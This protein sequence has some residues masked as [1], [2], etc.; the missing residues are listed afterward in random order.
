MT[1]A[2]F[3][4]TQTWLPYRKIRYSTGISSK[5][6]INGLPYQIPENGRASGVMLFF[7]FLKN[8]IV[9]FKSSEVALLLLKS[10]E[11]SAGCSK[12]IDWPEYLFQPMKTLK[13][14]RSICLCACARSIFV[15]KFLVHSLHPVALGQLSRC[16][17]CSVFSNTL[18]LN[19]VI[20]R[21]RSTS[22]SN[23]QVLIVCALNVW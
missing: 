23:S 17:F 11:L 12:S 20:C 5:Y 9:L 8:M 6:R 15:L 2:S 3:D 7:S 1:T 10:R 13:T 4:Y 22:T 14:T 18:D 19:F 16:N 21:P